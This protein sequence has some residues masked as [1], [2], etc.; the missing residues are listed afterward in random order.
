MASSSKDM[1]ASLTEL[2]KFKEETDELLRS[3]SKEG[4]GLQG[5]RDDHE[6]YY[7]RLGLLH[8]PAT[9][10]ETVTSSSSSSSSTSSSGA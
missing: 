9:E 4:G 3:L 6:P 2:K 10:R 8:E 7:Y 1:D 5:R